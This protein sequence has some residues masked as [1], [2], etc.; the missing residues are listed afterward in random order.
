MFQSDISKLLPRIVT[1]LITLSGI[2]A[3]S[4]QAR[5]LYLQMSQLPTS[6]SEAQPQLPSMSPQ[7]VQRLFGSAGAAAGVDLHGVQLQGCIVAAN[8]R[9]SQAL[10]QIPGQ[11][12]VNVFAGEEFLPGVMLQQ[13]A[14]DHVLFSRNGRSGRLDFPTAQA[15]SPAL[16]PGGAE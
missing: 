5:L 13:V 4:W 6:T 1:I 16:A 2:A 14:H 7:L 10:I 12:A 8:P 15:A 3:L 11:G 9:Q